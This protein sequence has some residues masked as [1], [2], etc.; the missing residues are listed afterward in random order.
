LASCS[1]YAVSF[2]SVIQ[3]LILTG[4]RQSELLEAEWSE[5]DLGG[6]MWTIPRACSKTDV[7]HLVPLSGLAS[8]IIEGLPALEILPPRFSSPPL[9]AHRFRCSQGAQPDQEECSEVHPTPDL[10]SLVKRRLAQMLGS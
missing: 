7:A 2:G 6:R 3:L 5:F 8:G 4:T 1:G 9:A 10:P